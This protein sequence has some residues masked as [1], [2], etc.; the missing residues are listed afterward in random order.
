MQ[1]NSSIKQLFGRPDFWAAIVGLASVVALQVFGIELDGEALL[2][3]I[4][5]I[6]GIFTA[7]QGAEAYQARKLAE[8][9]V[10]AA[11]TQTAAQAEVESARL[12][13]TAEKESAVEAAKIQAQA[14][15]GLQAQAQVQGEK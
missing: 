12:F 15:Y 2:A 1:N 6:V 13:A 10:N 7:S 4:M 9:Q 8:T 11:A 14:A 5:A 3:G